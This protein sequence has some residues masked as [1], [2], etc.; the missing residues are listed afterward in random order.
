M[1]ASGVDPLEWSWRRQDGCTTDILHPAIAV[2]KEC[3]GL[4]HEGEEIH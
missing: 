2:V 1:T 3:T 4:V